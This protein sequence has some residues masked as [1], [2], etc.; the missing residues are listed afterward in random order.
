M[1][2]QWNDAIRKL[3]G[4]APKEKE[5]GFDVRCMK[6]DREFS[7]PSW[8]AKFCRECAKEQVT[9]LTAVWE[10]AYFAALTGT[11]RDSKSCEVDVGLAANIANATV[12]GW[13][14]MTAER[15]ALIRKAVGG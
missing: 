14:A 2:G 11:A 15:D 3:P 1:V 13:P 9:E 10:R 7:A 4:P 12:A 6:C 8:S 5:M